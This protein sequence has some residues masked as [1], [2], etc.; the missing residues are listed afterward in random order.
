MARSESGTKAGQRRRRE[1]EQETMHANRT[2]P[3]STGNEPARAQVDGDEDQNDGGIERE[4]PIG[5][6]RDDRDVERERP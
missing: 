1:P 2:K 4:S 6:I 3:M 5:D